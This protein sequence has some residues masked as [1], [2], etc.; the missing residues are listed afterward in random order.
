MSEITELIKKFEAGEVEVYIKNEEEYK[1]FQT[2]FVPHF[3]FYHEEETSGWAM[4]FKTH[5]WDEILN[6]FAKEDEIGF[7]HDAITIDCITKFDK[8]FG[9]VSTISVVSTKHSQNVVFN[10]HDLKI[11]AII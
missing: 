8:D 6:G 7:D 1:K 5:T 11:N 4:D 10:K 9:N 3:T 2:Q